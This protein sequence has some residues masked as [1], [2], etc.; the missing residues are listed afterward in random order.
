MQDKKSGWE[1]HSTT[2]IY[3]ETDAAQQGDRDL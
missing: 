2:E 1:R 3:K